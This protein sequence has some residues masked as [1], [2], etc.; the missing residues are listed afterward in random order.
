[1]LKNYFY[2]IKFFLFEN[3]IKKITLLLVIL[4]L[5]SSILELVGIFLLAIL[6]LLI[7]GQELPQFLIQSKYLGS[8]AIESYFFFF[9][10][11]LFFFLKNIY[12][13]STEYI[14]SIVISSSYLNFQKKNIHNFIFKNYLSYKKQKE[15]DFNKYINYSPERTFIGMG[16]SFYS[17]INE[18]CI[19]IFILALLSF[20]LTP[21]V[22]VGS[23]FV[24]LIYFYI[25]KK[26]KNYTYSIGKTLNL[27]ASKIYSTSEAIFKGF[28]EIKIYNKENRFIDFFNITIKDYSNA[29][30]SSRFIINI[31]K[32]INE[33][34]IISIIVFFLISLKYF[35][36]S[37]NG[38][39]FSFTALAVSIIRL[40]PNMTKIQNTIS[41]I[42][43]ALP[44][45]NELV[46]NFKVNQNTSILRSKKQ[47]ENLS[48]DQ[49]EKIKINL[50]DVN[51]SYHKDPLLKNINVSFNSGEK[52]LIYGPSGGGK[53][54]LLELICGLLE[55]KFGEITINNAET[56]LI[57]TNLISYVPQDSYLIDSNMF[58]NITLFDEVNDTNIKKAINAAKVCGLSSF[59]GEIDNYDKFILEKSVKDLS[60]GQKQRL[61]LARAVYQN[62]KILI[63]D[64]PTSNL[65]KKTEDRFFENIFQVFEKKIIVVVSHNLD[66][67]EQFDKVLIVKNGILNQVEKVS[68]RKLI[69]LL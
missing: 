31:L 44:I 54:T 33:T 26:I 21:K 69:N 7:T 61:S 8:F 57:D 43:I 46:N 27:N 50:K 23:L 1:M 24:S 60:S 49:D 11:I 34:I 17:L 53:T 25:F 15:S 64:E 58:D 48:F 22:I 36:I 28:K 19:F 37:F 30:K 13:S 39:N 5:F 29:F 47:I 66:N 18:L 2:N 10:I 67:F 9:L 38:M 16:E 32:Y 40:Y 20:T 41:Q 3:T 12:I 6:A 59:I 65:D 4:I 45:A 68:L 55:P 51:F 42:N 35:D 14:K 63:L 62:R 56:K 52:Y